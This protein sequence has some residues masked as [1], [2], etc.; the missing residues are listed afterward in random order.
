MELPDF[1]SLW[2]AS[3]TLEK[4]Q[5]SLLKDYFPQNHG[6]AQNVSCNPLHYLFALVALLPLPFGPMMC[7]S[8]GP[9]SLSCLHQLCIAVNCIHSWVKSRSIPPNLV[10]FRGVVFLSVLWW[11]AMFQQFNR[12]PHSYPFFV[13]VL[14][15]FGRH[16]SQLF[17]LLACHTELTANCWER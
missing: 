8:I 16:S 1:S 17:F 4:L 15:A 5:E 9:D 10:D 6:N 2:E 7:R 11:S 3:S 13:T 12:T 14:I